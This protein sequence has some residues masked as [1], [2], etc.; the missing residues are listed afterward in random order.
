MASLRAIARHIGYRFTRRSDRQ[1]EPKLVHVIACGNTLG[2]G[3]QWNGEDGCA[4]WTDIMESTLHCCDLVG[5][6]P[7]VIALPERLGCFAFARSGTRMLLALASGIAWFD[8]ASGALEWIARPE[9]GVGG[10]RSNDGRCDRQG[11]FWVGTCVEDGSAGGPG[12][13]LY[14][15]RADGRVSTHLRGLGTSNSLCWSPDGGT[16]Y[17]ADSPSRTIL[18]YDFD[19]AEG[20]LSRP[21]VF[22]RTEPGVYP[23]GACVDREGGVWNA[24][25]GGA[26]VRRYWPNGSIDFDI[27]MPVS[28]PTCVAFG[29]SELDLLLVST[30]RAGLDPA[31]RA[32]QP[33]AGHVLVCDAGMRGLPESRFG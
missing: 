12:A 25:W 22:A 9:A 5:Q 6:A 26:R 32:A 15:L 2:E 28:Q 4:W 33:L 20:T 16:L 13:A 8:R 18:A 11:R 17:H 23:D 27:R 31:Q 30:A 10:N 29:G 19:G 24:Q 7:K 21:R 1:L 14:C 3:I